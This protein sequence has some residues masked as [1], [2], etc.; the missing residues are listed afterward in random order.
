MLDYAFFSLIVGPADVRFQ[1]VGFGTII[2]N[3]VVV[4]R[5]GIVVFRAGKFVPGFIRIGSSVFIQILAHHHNSR[6][7]AVGVRISQSF[8]VVF[9]FHIYDR[10]IKA[11]DYIT[12]K[13]SQPK[14]R[15][16]INQAI[17]CIFQGILRSVTHG[18]SGVDAVDML[19]GSRTIFQH[20]GNVGGVLCCN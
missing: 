10:V 17:L 7:A 14:H 1:S 6:F 20:P 8:E 12:A 19:A 2:G 5:R 3:F 16:I 13:T 11:N 15:F 18:R 9:T 4:D